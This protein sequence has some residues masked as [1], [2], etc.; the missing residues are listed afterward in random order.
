MGLTAFQQRIKDASVKRLQDTKYHCEK[1]MYRY[2]DAKDVV[3]QITYADAKRVY[4]M[5]KEELEIRGHES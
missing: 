3:G 1:M 5:V 2:C 4:A